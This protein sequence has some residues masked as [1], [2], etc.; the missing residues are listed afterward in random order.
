MLSSMGRILYECCK[1]DVHCVFHLSFLNDCISG[2]RYPNEMGVNF[3]VFRKNHS[4]RGLVIMNVF[5]GYT[6]QVGE[7]DEISEVY[8]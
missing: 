6:L 7:H 4:L 2:Y 1:L 5:F 8:L 3:T